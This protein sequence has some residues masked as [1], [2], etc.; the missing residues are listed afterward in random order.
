MKVNYDQVIRGAH[1]CFRSHGMPGPCRTCGKRVSPLHIP[2]HE[3]GGYCAAHCAAC[4]EQ[5]AI[6]EQALCNARG[7]AK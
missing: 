5:P 4:A 6:D 1:D 3:K 2:L 7:D